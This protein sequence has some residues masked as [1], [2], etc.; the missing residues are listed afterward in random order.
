MHACIISDIRLY[1]FEIR[2]LMKGMFR[3][4]IG[5]V[6]IWDIY[7]QEH[8]EYHKNEKWFFSIGKQYEITYEFF[9][10]NYRT[11]FKNSILSIY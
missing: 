3:S 2:N 4:V 5:H 10:L 7:S 8:E 6:I 1:I 9:L 11:D